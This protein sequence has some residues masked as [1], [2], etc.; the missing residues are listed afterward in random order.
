LLKNNVIFDCK[1][2]VQLLRV[3]LHVEHGAVQVLHIP[4]ESIIMGRV[5]LGQAELQVLDDK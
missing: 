1:Q 2:E 5:P 3:I 4:D